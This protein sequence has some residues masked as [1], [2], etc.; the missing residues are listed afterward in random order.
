MNP[1]IEWYSGDGGLLNESCVCEHHPDG[2]PGCIDQRFAEQ[3]SPN[4]LEDWNQLS[5]A[6]LGAW[7]A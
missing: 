6:W 1:G 7:D 5:D 4:P 2:A 3:Q